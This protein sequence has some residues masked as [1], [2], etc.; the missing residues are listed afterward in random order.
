MIRTIILSSITAYP[1]SSS[2][3]SVVAPPLHTVGRLTSFLSIS[4]RSLNLA[5][6]LWP[7][8]RAHITSIYNPASTVA[9]INVAPFSVASVIRRSYP[10]AIQ[11]PHPAAATALICPYSYSSRSPL[12]MPTEPLPS[13]TSARGPCHLCSVAAAVALHTAA[14]PFTADL[15]HHYSSPF[16]PAAV[17]SSRPPDHYPFFLPCRY[18]PCNFL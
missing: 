14:P 8:S 11:L 2:P 16:S 13:S 18:I 10:H 3:L 15:H 4:G 12:P 6:T 17:A 9:T 7:P 1:R 5:S